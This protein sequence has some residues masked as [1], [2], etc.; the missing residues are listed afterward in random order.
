[1]VFQNE[2]CLGVFSSIIDFIGLLKPSE[3]IMKRD[4][5]SVHS[6]VFR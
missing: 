1:M 4:G 3:S 5:L 6:L 2:V